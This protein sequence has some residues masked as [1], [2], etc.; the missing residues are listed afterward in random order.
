MDEFTAKVYGFIRARKLLDDGDSVIAGVSGGSDS[1]CLLSVLHEIGSIMHLRVTAV[2]VNHGLRGAAADAD[3]LFTSELCGRLGIK[4]LVYS[5]DIARMAREE[6]LTEEEAGR[7]F[8]YRCFEDAAQKEGAGRIAVAHH[9][10]DQCET[11]L[12]NLFRGSG[13]SGLTGIRE[14]RGAVVRPLLCVRKKEIEAYLAERS[15]EYCTDLTNFETDHTRNRIRI[16]IMPYVREN[17]NS[18]ADRHIARMSD[19]LSDIMNHIENEAAEAAGRL[20]SSGS[21]GSGGGETSLRIMSAGFAELDTAVQRELV[22]MVLGRA[23][24]RLK[25]I[26]S[27][28]IEAVRELF[29]GRTGSRISLP[30]G[31]SAVKEYGYICISRET[32]QA[33]GDGKMSPGVGKELEIGPDGELEVCRG[34]YKIR[35]SLRHSA[36]AGTDKIAQIPQKIYTKCFDYG[37]IKCG[38]SLRHRLDGDYMMISGGRKKLL[39]RILID[40][41]VPRSQRDGVLLLADGEHVMW[42]IDNG[43][44]SEYYKLT[45]IT[46]DIL[47]VDISEIG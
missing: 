17:I 13:A 21:S 18:E 2:H 14:K 41:K 1:V 12:M 10:D 40:D 6:H 11:V 5:A 43:R 28:H 20:V 26:E 4:C 19:I 47:T 3:Q 37:R 9:M 15:L 23:A 33:G 8:R 39:R 32:G 34:R 30:Y 38:L 22:R 35:L 46:E 24:G 42:I 31:L 7:Q 25:D 45:N 29:C 36:P 44:I 27:V 16:D